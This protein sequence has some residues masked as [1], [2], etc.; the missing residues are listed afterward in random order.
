M[1]RLPLLQLHLEG[2]FKKF[3]LRFLAKM[4]LNAGLKC[5]L[6]CPH[7]SA[8]FW[9]ELKCLFELLSLSSGENRAWTLRTLIRLF[10]V[11]IQTAVVT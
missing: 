5:L 11:V 7:L 4:I 9:I 10:V 6:K 3:M 2:D 1:R 8:W